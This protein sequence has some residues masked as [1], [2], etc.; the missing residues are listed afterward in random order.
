[1]QKLT[2]AVEAKAL[3]TLRTGVGQYIY[4]LYSAIEKRVDKP[5]LYYQID[6]HFVQTLPHERIIPA[7]KSPLKNKERLSKFL[8]R[9]GVQLVLWKKKLARYAYRKAFNQQLQAIQPDLIHCTDFFS[10]NNSA[11]IAE[12]ITVYDL[13]CFRFPETHPAARVKFFNEYLPTSLKNARHILTISEFSK[14]EIVDYF[15]IDPNKITVAYCG[16]PTG[17]KPYSEKAVQ[18][19]LAAHGLQYKKYFL[20]VGTI[21][22]RKNLA[23]LLEAFEQLPAAIKAEYQLVIIG[24]HGWKFERFLQA[25]QGLLDKRQLLM[26]GYVADQELQHLMAGAH[27]FLYPSLYE[28]FGIPPLEAMASGTAVVVSNATSLPEVVGEA[29]VLLPC[30]DAA[31][32]AQAMVRLVE[33]R[34]QY[35]AYVQAGLARA[36][37]FNWDAT[38]ETV[39]NCFKR[40]S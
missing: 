9:F 13:S 16:L 28:G 36:A 31:Q 12:I 27:S 33:D 14:Q 37:L 1:M 24:A 6:S 35:Q 26:P 11:G 32:W 7:N 30:D 20:Y 40:H 10:L 19:S 23:L 34:Q 5:E 2:I 4:Q 21:E 25:A 39:L 3:A 8:D 17:F 22:P 38:A 29:G 18:G 15:A